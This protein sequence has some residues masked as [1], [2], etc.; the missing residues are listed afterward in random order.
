MTDF[1]DREHLITEINKISKANKQQLKP[2]IIKLTRNLA[3]T[4]K[5]PEVIIWAKLEGI[6][7][8][9]PKDVC[10]ILLRLKKKN[11]WV[12][13]RT[14]LYDYCPAEFK[15]TQKE[16]SNENKPV[17]LT[18]DYLKEN[19]EDIMDRIKEINK[20][21]AKDIKIKVR[22]DMVDLQEWNNELSLELM[23]LAK[24]IHETFEEKDKELIKE[25]A[26]RVRMAR[27]ARFATTWAHYEGI[28]A[29]VSASKSLNKA[30]EEEKYPLTRIEVIKN[31]HSCRECYCDG[32]P[33]V[34]GKSSCKCH[35][36][37]TVQEMTTKGL[38]W[39]LKHNKKLGEFD[40]H[41]KRIGN[42]DHEDLCPHI[43]TMFTNPNMDKHLTQDTK[44]SLLSAHIE[45]EK[46]V[47]CEMF[48]DS[49][50]DFFG[51]D[52]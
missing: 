13:S 31:E 25:I 9:Q 47:L 8:P 6:E 20:G 32:E 12:F 40:E 14:T 28:V 19:I 48:R 45:R 41:Y 30:I 36:H 35:C 44:L 1:E 49:H 16:Q 43:K 15:E 51:I 42:M 29:A 11:D 22:K 50:P 2:L 18:D 24:K 17:R 39:A 33:K 52:I 7:N 23:L 34:S 46:C 38:K 27:D 26:E 4:L 10:R 37:R 5:R 3:K 21:P